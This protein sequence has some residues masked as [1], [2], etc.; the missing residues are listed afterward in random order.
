MATYKYKLYQRP[1]GPE[2]AGQLV[3]ELTIEADDD[4]SAIQQ[5]KNVR[6]PFEFEADYVALCNHDDTVIW[7]LEAPGA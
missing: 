5:A 2:T 1:G 6:A 3:D 7:H 4:A